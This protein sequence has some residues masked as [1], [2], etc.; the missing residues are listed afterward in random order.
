M[1][2]QSV[3][4]REHVYTRLHVYYI[5]TRRHTT[6]RRICRATI[7][8]VIIEEIAVQPPPNPPRRVTAYLHTRDPHN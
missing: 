8:L 3:N 6:R 4:I 7:A 5:P 1:A 2:F